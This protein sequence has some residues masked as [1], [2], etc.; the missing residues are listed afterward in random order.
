MIEETIRLEDQLSAFDAMISSVELLSLADELLGEESF[1]G[2]EFTNLAQADFALSPLNFSVDDSNLRPE[3]WKEVRM[4][5]ILVKEYV[6]RLEGLDEAT[7]KE[8]RAK[9]IIEVIILSHY[10]CSFSII[11]V[12]CRQRKNWLAK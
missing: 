12:I 7:L 3:Y 2:I 1:E 11:I 8:K 10:R 5:R 6:D 9:R 4:R